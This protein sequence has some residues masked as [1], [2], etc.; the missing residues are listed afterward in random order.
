MNVTIHA[1][2]AI[3]IQTTMM[4]NNSKSVSK[5][6]TSTLSCVSQKHLDD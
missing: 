3:T 4:Y 5:F 1:Q 2:P 6:L